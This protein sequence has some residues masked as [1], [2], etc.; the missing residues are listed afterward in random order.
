MC[1]LTHW[2][3]QSAGYPLTGQEPRPSPS[4][5]LS[6]LQ[7]VSFGGFMAEIRCPNRRLWRFHKAFGTETLSFCWCCTV[8]II[9]CR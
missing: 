3:K 9:E 5:M 6:V 4:R 1:H 2:K 7:T 8:R